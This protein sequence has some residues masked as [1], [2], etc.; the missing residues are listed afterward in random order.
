MTGEEEFN[1]LVSDA[2]SPSRLSP[3]YLVVGQPGMTYY[4][5]QK[6]GSMG[7]Q[8]VDGGTHQYIHF[9]WMR[10]GEPEG[11]RYIY[12][13]VYDRNTDAFTWGEGDDAG[14][15]VDNINGGYTT[16][17]VTS[18]GA[19][20]LAFH[21]GAAS[22][23]Y[24]S[25]ASRDFNPPFAAFLDMNNNPA[26][27]PPNCQ[28][29]IT[30][31]YEATSQYIWPVV[32]LDMYGGD[33]I[34]HVVS[35][36]GPPAVADVSEIQTIIYYRNVNGDWTDHGG[37]YAAPCALA[38]DSVYTI[39]AVVRA[40]ANSDNVAIVWLKPMYYVG[41][42]G[43]PCD[44]YWAQSDVVYQ[45]SDDAGLTWNPMVNVT[46]YSQGHTLTPDQME[47]QAYTDVSAMYSSD[48]CL[49]I[50]WNTPL[51][52]LTGDNPCA[53]LYASR[54]WH[55]D[56]CNQC[57]SLVFDASRPRYFCP[58]GAFM[59]STGKMNISEC[60]VSDSTR[61]YVLFSRMGAHTSEDGGTAIDCSDPNDNGNYCNSEL[62]LSG[63]TDGGLTWGPDPSLPIYVDTSDANTGPVQVGSAVNL[64]N[65]YTPD[66]LP[67]ECMSEHWAS[68]A[69]YA[70]DSNHIFY[71]EDK[72]AG[73]GIRDDPQE[74][75]LTPNPVMYMTTGC[76]WPGSICGMVATPMDISITIAPQGGSD[77]TVD[78]AAQFNV[79]LTNTGN[80]PITYSAVSDSPWVATP[81]PNGVIGV[82]CDA[83][84]TLVYTVGPYATEG[85]Y[86]IDITIT[87]MCGEDELVAVVNVNVY[88]KCFPPEYARLS[89]ACWA[90]D[91]WNVPRAG[92]DGVEGQ[93][94]WL[95]N[96]MPP[97]G[98]PVMFDE[99]A[100]ITYADDTCQTW[101]SLF[102][103]GDA[104][105]S[106]VPLGPLTTAAFPSYEYAHG[107]WA[108]GEYEFDPVDTPSI[109]GEVEYYVPIHPDTCVLIERL[110][111]C[112]GS[113]TS[114]TIHV[115]EAIDWDIPDTTD[116]SENQCG[117]DQ[118]RQMV[119]QHGPA[120]TAEENYYGGASF[121]CSIP[122]A[123]VLENADWIYPNSGFDPCEVGGLLARHTGFEATTPDSL[124][125]MISVYVIAQDLVIEPDSCVV[126]CKVKASSITG[127][128][129]L[130]DLIDKGKA[131]I[132]LNGI[133]CPCGGCDALPGDPNNSGGFDIDDVVYLIAYIFSGGPAP[134]P[135][136]V[137]NGDPNCSCGIDIDDVVY[138]IAY[139]FSGGPPPCSCEDW[140]AA[141]GPLQ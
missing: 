86:S 7:R 48:G 113:D 92:G 19:A 28:G 3:R 95:P 66:C 100:I 22:G 89:T 77:C 115:G 78:E 105:V 59:V 141:C 39:N 41:D 112:N 118:T 83:S 71:V 15:K 94:F 6:N 9:A 140:V 20:V 133:D 17:D 123:I 87:G 62:F 80:Q 138:M 57:I 52:D 60:T 43:D 68:M 24:K 93:M 139:I 26:P 104:G 124:Q 97:D 109:V 122:G 61:L 12:Y 40:D 51:R 137:A 2:T 63:S 79:Q 119:Y 127:L 23:S 132:S 88:V 101:F 111:V 114:V 1:G 56:D 25:Y 121:V 30:G 136:A 53:A 102:D 126:Y 58:T 82:G 116:G 49:H 32:A 8:V 85:R 47:H 90:I 96:L 110:T 21:H 65:T 107:L 64:T 117:A 75:T 73:A 33:T 37:A 4:D 14:K 98:M 13:N 38:I 50:V 44:I 125:D 34:I 135:Y 108:I 106:L 99:S 81:S 130:Q 16:I 45:E 36:E 76:F 18:W 54:L 55:W 70:I 131:W 120:G 27:G 42:P 5:F 72:D 46:D 74:G 128:A 84:A 134:V 103:G 11:D 10:W 29:W 91:V 69:M 67:G 31:N 129:D 35:T